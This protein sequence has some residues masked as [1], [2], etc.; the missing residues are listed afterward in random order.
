LERLVCVGE[1]IGQY[2]ILCPGGQQRNE[3]KRQ[4]QKREKGQ[5]RL[6]KQQKRVLELV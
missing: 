4:G 6:G 2:S 3:H 1:S 5:G